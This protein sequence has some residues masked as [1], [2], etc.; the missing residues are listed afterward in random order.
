MGLTNSKIIYVLPIS[1]GGPMA[2]IHPVWGPLHAQEAAPAAIRLGGNEWVDP[3]SY[4]T[5]LSA[6]YMLLL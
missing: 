4:L 3:V 1:L 5:M 2:A 6:F